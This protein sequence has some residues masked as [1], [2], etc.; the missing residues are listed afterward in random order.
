MSAHHRLLGLIE[1]AFDTA[2][3]RSEAGGGALA[4]PV[5]HQAPLS[6]TVSPLRPRRDGIG[7]S[8]PAA[9]ILVRDP[10]ERVDITN[11][12]YELF[13]LTRS[14]ALL[15]NGLANGLTIQ[16]GRAAVQPMCLFWDLRM[17]KRL[18]LR[19]KTHMSYEELEKFLEIHCQSPVRVL[20]E[21]LEGDAQQ[22]RKV[23]ILVFVTEQDRE[24]FRAAFGGRSG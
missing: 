10:G 7:L 14:E 15:A 1:G 4:V 21:G 24:K 22:A 23:M 12:A 11:L 5:E 16:G 2:A 13:G 9:L 3:G 17:A 18:S 8:D 6:V 19:L 20:F